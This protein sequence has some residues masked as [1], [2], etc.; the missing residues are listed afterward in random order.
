MTRKVCWLLV[1]L[2]VSSVAVPA[3][4]G[5]GAAPALLPPETITTPPRIDWLDPTNGE[6]MIAQ[7]PP[8]EYVILDDELPSGWY[9][10]LGVGIVKPHIHGRITSGVPVDAMLPT[11]MR[12]P[13]APLDWTALPDVK[14]GYRFAGSQDELRLRYQGLFSQGRQ[15][16]TDFDKW[17]S[18]VVQSRLDFNMVDVDYVSR[19]FIDRFM[20]PAPPRFLD[21]LFGLRTGNICFE[22]VG[23]GTQVIAQGMRNGFAGIGPHLGMD[24]S[25]ALWGPRLGAYLLLDTA[26]LIGSLHQDFVDVRF[27]KNGNIV[28]GEL[29]RRDCIGVG[30]LQFEPGL[31][32][33]P[34]RDPRFRV[35]VGYTWQRWWFLGNSTASDADL[36]IQGIMFRGE[37][38][39]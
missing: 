33:L 18:G 21:I 3:A 5:Q 32:F 9:V 37:F 16:F 2:T 10:A 26:G 11:A 36:T 4:L 29:R 39:F 22:N 25:R 31:R 38:S 12:L 19:E 35:S 30:T 27:T 13:S 8:G 14:I 17:G 20:G 28:G 6:T 1:A 7:A 15:F 23:F 34:L 24:Y